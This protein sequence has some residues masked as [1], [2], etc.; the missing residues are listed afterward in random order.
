[1]AANDEC[2][3]YAEE[4]KRLAKLTDCPPVR[5]QLLD[6]AR[7]WAAV[8]RHERRDDAPVVVFLPAGRRS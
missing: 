7:G 2:M 3:R 8:A 6:L 4:F 5:D 1:M